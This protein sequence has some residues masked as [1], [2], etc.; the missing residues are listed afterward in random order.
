MAVRLTGNNFGLNR[1]SMNFNSCDINCMYWL[2]GNSI[3]FRHSYF[4]NFIDR[5]LA[6]KAQTKF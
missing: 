6:T 2:S 3:H 5:K 4:S 1:N